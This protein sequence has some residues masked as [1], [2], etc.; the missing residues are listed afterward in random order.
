VSGADPA[1]RFGKDV[2]HGDVRTSADRAQIGALYQASLAETDAAIG[3][4]LARLESTG[5]LDDTVV[6]LTAD[7]GEGLY[8]CATCIGHG[9]N[10]DGMMSLRVPLAFRLPRPRFA[11]AAPATVPTYVSQLDVYPTLLALLDSARPSVQEGIALL[12]RDGAILAPPRDRVFFAES[13]EWLW[14]TPAIPSARIAYPPITALAR[15]EQGRIVI[16]EAFLPVI[17]AAKHR[18]AILPPFKLLYLP[19]PSGVGWRLYDIERD[20]G[21]ERDISASQPEVTARLRE[22]LRH[23]VLRF[24]HMLPAG[25]YFL[26]R[27]PSLPEEY[28]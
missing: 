2:T 15:I 6:V 16:E 14:P 11:A 3:D 22:A 9:D 7:H 25:D 27:P 4:L 21:E 28:Y 13:G 17:R 8:E 10:L 5:A 20:P 12:A 18:T 23:S 26:T 24:S 19:T 1:L